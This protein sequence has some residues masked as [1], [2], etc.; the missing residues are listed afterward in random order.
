MF[1][2]LLSPYVMLEHGSLVCGVMFFCFMWCNVFLL[3]VSGNVFSE[4]IGSE[5]N[6]IHNR[7]IIQLTVPHFDD[8]SDWDGI[9]VS[10]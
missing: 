6:A 7:R 4:R 2:L 1:V 10:D 5:T 3:H 8:L 9:R